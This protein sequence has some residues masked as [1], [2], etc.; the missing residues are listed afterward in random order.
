[1][2]NDTESEII[3]IFSSLQKEDCKLIGDDCA[4][5]KDRDLVITT[6]HFA[7][8][9]HFD[10]SYMPAD[11]V[12]WRLMA[13]N[14]SDILS[15]GLKP[16]YF[17]LNLAVPDNRRTIIKDIYKGISDFS[18]KYGIHIAG[19]DTTAS[20]SVFISITMFA[21]T[22]GNSV[23]KRSTAQPGDNIF[24]PS[25]P[26]PGG[27]LTGFLALSENI[28]GFKQ[29]KKRFLYPDPFETEVDNNLKINSAIDISDGLLRELSLISR[30]SGANISVNLDS[31]PCS[32]EL[33]K[34]AEQFKK[35]LWEIQLTSGEEFFLVLSSPEE[36]IPFY[37]KI[38]EV[39]ERGK[40]NVRF[41]KNGNIFNPDISSVFKHFS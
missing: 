33:K 35:P 25:N 31:F 9:H 22:D 2:K 8:N 6:D 29:S 21:S 3:K 19:G 39:K 4:V 7:E 1:M 24:I 5:L 30:A 34:A 23:W 41:F 16:E 15:M 17:L 11:S 10:F 37:V 14:A 20:D 27:A 40:G 13:A 32:E 18:K 26:P 36:N 12:G 28:E 38:G